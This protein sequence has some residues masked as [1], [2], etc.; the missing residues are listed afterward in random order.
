[1][2]K[3][4]W[5]SDL[6]FL[7]GDKTVAGHDPRVRLSAAVDHIR[8]HHGDAQVFVISGDLVNEGNAV[9][10][11]ALKAQLSILD[12]ECLLMVGNHDDRA[13]MAKVFDKPV[14]AMPDY[15]QYQR[16]LMVVHLCFWTR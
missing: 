8:R 5:M 13:E 16:R 3:L 15:W 14:G 6:H 1:M 2:A 10:Y 4:I 9:D 12:I 7:A 11:R